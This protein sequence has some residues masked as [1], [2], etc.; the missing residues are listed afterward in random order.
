[1]GSDSAWIPRATDKSPRCSSKCPIGS[2][3]Q[4][5]PGPA[6]LPRA[7]SR[8]TAFKV[9]KYR[10]PD[11]LDC[12]YFLVP[13]MPSQDGLVL[14]QCFFSKLGHGLLTPQTLYHSAGDGGV[15]LRH[16][17]TFP[18]YSVLP[19]PVLRIMF[20]TYRGGV[21]EIQRKYPTPL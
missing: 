13:V 20:L 16:C 11:C 18:P 15:F 6:G 10:K 8:L 21:K 17:M 7:V 3:A 1:M 9:D 2:T 4:P 5:C 14:D 19:I 12:L